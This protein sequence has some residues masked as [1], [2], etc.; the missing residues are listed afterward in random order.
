MGQS[1]FARLIR[2]CRSLA[3][4]AFQITSSRLLPRRQSTT[5]LF[6]TLYTAKYAQPS[7]SRIGSNACRVGDVPARA[8]CVSTLRPIH[9]L[10]I[11]ASMGF[12]FTAQSMLSFQS[13][14][15]AGNSSSKSIQ[16]VRRILR[17]ATENTCF[18]SVCKGVSKKKVC[19]GLPQRYRVSL[20]RSWIFLCCN[21]PAVCYN[22]IMVMPL[23]M[24]S[25]CFYTTSEAATYLGF[26]E[27]TIRRY[28]Y[29]G[30]IDGR[31]RGNTL[32]VT[33]SELDRY[34]QEKRNPGRQ[35]KS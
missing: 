19:C 24:K 28:I 3:S 5:T 21:C 13:R 35:K 15:L 14:N 11:C 25:D 1:A 30:L 12:I 29:R 2:D 9:R 23:Q 31:K 18:P 34:K 26:A 16:K 7:N 17:R 33:K 10:A 8:G 27:D 20:T 6:G 32:L 4:Y 22:R